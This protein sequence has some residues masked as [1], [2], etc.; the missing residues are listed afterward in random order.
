MVAQGLQSKCPTPE[1]PLPQFLAQ[2]YAA[3]HPEMRTNNREGFTNGTTSG[4]RWYPVIGSM[5]VP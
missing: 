5:Q 2:V 1:D 3:N 4:A